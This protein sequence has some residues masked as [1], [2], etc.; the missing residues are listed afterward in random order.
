M[1]K[2]MFKF[3]DLMNPN[4]YVLETKFGN[5]VRYGRKGDY[6]VTGD[7]RKQILSLCSFFTC[8]FDYGLSVY[9]KWLSGKPIYVRI[10]NSTTDF[11]V[12]K[13]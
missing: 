13:L 2:M 7:K 1:E 11:L 8:E 4:I 6:V 3:L 9:E 5:I 12:P 10:K